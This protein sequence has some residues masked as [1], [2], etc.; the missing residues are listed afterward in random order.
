MRRLV[1]AV[2]KANEM[3][4]FIN[5]KDSIMVGISCGKDSTLLYYALKL[6]ANQLKLKRNW[7]VKVYGIHIK[8]NFNKDIRYK[9]YLRWI[10]Q[11][12]LDIKII[13]SNIAEVLEI[14]KE[15]NRIQ[16]SLCSKMK[17]AILIKEAKKLHC[18]KIAMGHHIDDAIETIFLNM[19]N[20]GRIATFKP[21]TYLDRSNMYLIRPFILC[22][23]KDIITVSKKLKVPIIKMMCPNEKITQRAYFKKFIEKNFYNNKLFVNGYENFRNMLLNGKNSDLWFYDENTKNKDLLAILKKGKAK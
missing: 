6:Y 21:N 20:E 14:K 16:C 17:K 11:Q 13:D 4:N 15:N 9:R 12:N 18:N 1:G 10:K 19:V 3:F 8:P 2:I 5:D 7:D 22:N 23:E